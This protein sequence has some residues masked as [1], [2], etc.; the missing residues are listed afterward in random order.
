MKTMKLVTM[1]FLAMG[2]LFV[3]CE[4]EGPAG[5]Q[6]EIGPPGPAGA[7]GA[8]GE[9][10]EQGIQGEQGEEGNA[11]VI[12]SG[13]IDSTFPD[14]ER[15]SAV[16]DQ[17]D[18]QLTADVIDNAAILAYARDGAASDPNRRVYPLPFLVGERNFY[19]DVIIGRIRFIAV[20]TGTVNQNFS[21]L[22]AFRYVIIPQSTMA[23]GNQPNFEKMSYAEVMDHF[24]LDH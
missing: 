20:R 9:Q 19:T 5:P 15:F 4:K 1:L 17:F 10:G 21:F 11:N 24:G 23:K 3:S 14:E 12:A 8:D 16:Q 7:D 18:E 2:V 13:W 6:G 22:D